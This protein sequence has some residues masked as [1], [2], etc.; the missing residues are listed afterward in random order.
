MQ[1][2]SPTAAAAAPD[3]A[4]VRF[5]AVYLLGDVLGKTCRLDT[6]PIAIERRIVTRAGI[7]VVA[8][9]SAIGFHHVAAQ[10]HD[11]GKT[12]HELTHHAR[13]NLLMA[14][15]RAFK[16]MVHRSEEHTSELQSLMRISY[17]VF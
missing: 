7:N 14:S 12:A 9:M 16:W 13:E 1:R 6:G 8:D 3:I 15:M 11:H 10:P 5:A 17:A 2:R 4:V